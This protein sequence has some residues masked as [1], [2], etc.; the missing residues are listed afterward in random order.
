MNKDKFNYKW[1]ID[2]LSGLKQKDDYRRKWDIDMENIDKTDYEKNFDW[3]KYNYCYDSLKHELCKF[4][5]LNFYDILVTDNLEE[6]ISFDKSSSTSRSPGFPFPSDISQSF[7]NNTVVP[8]RHGVHFPQ[9]S[10]RK[11]R[12]Q[13]RTSVRGLKLEP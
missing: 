4:P 6:I 11:K 12:I 3:E 13:P 10:S 2:T 7:S 8:T 9:L 5:E 1:C